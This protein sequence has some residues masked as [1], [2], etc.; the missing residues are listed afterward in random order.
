MKRTQHDL[1]IPIRNW[2]RLHPTL[3][4]TYENSIGFY[5]DLFQQ[6]VWQ[7]LSDK[8]HKLDTK[9]EANLFVCVIATEE[10]SS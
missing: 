7:I 5:A 8:W 9:I 4:D 3:N 2:N 1:R 10:I 6:L